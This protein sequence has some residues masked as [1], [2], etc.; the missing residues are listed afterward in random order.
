MEFKPGFPMAV[1]LVVAKGMLVAALLLN[2]LSVQDGSAGADG[3][4]WI[5]E[6]RARQQAV[7]VVELRQQLDSLVK[8]QPL[9]HG[10]GLNRGVIGISL[11]RTHNDITVNL[12]VGQL[13]DGYDIISG[14]L[15][16]QLKKIADA[17]DEI[18][19]GRAW[20]TGVRFL[21]G[22]KDIYF[23]YPHE[24]PTY[25]GSSNGGNSE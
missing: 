20:T 23:Y 12:E 22:G 5:S 6:L 2:P 16:D 24:R 9:I 7:I 10:Q 8:S 13:Q 25:P 21:F 4:P 11:S 18:V 3:I 14:Q 17:A 15:D 1:K 19:A